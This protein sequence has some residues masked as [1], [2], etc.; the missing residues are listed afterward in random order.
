M[1]DPRFLEDWKVLENL[2]IGPDTVIG[3]WNAVALPDDRIAA[4]SELPTPPFDSAVLGR[5][6][7]SENP[8]SD[9]GLD[10]SI[11]PSDLFPD[12]P[13]D[14]E[15]MPEEESGPLFHSGSLGN[16][17]DPDILESRS[18]VAKI[19]IDVPDGNR[20]SVRLTLSVDEGF[21]HQK[22]QRVALFTPA[23]IDLPE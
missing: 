14:P 20:F 4:Q 19:L 18:N 1:T 15:T 2:P 5:G 10:I 16:E 23:E 3:V 13:L 6:S 11:W 9:R 12:D 17:S 22:L 21:A 8:R 7:D